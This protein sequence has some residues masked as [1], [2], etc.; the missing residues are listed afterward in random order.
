MVGVAGRRTPARADLAPLVR[1]HVHALRGTT[2]T[3]RT[4]SVVPDELSPVRT[5]AFTVFEQS[6][7]QV[8]QRVLVL[9]LGI[10]AG[11]SACGSN[12]SGAIDDHNL[13]DV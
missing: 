3:D 7:D 11:A 13:W 12:H 8:T 10:A 5:G 6:V 2:E 1:P 9:Q 4:L